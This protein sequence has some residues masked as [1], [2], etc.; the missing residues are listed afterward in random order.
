MLHLGHWLNPYVEHFFIYS[1]LKLS[2]GQ[3]NGE[4]IKKYF[5]K[6]K[7]IFNRLS[8]TRGYLIFVYETTTDFGYL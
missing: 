8:L 2:I 5:F 7:N 3:V 4:K 1:V 6:S